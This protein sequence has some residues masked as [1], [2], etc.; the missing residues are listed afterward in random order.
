MYTVLSP[1]SGTNIQ[2]IEVFYDTILFNVKNYDGDDSLY[3][4]DIVIS[5]FD[6]DYNTGVLESVGAGHITKFGSTSLSAPMNHNGSSYLKSFISDKTKQ[7]LICGLSSTCPLIYK[8]TL[9]T[10]DLHRIYPNPDQYLE[11]TT[12]GF[13]SYNTDS[14]AQV[15]IDGMDVQ[16]VIPM[17]KD[18]VPYLLMPTIDTKSTPS[19]CSNIQALS[20]ISTQDMP[21][22]IINTDESI[23]ALQQNNKVKLFKL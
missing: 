1:I 21:L 2:S 18:T 15:T 12:A 9:N 8:Y 17:I 19:V 10:G 7:L 5:Q 3:Y 23:L 22:A 16:Y 6:F 20:G 13:G 14:S 11:W 4:N